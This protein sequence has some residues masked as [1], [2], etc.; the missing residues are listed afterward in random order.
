MNQ[1]ETVAPEHLL[2]AYCAIKA[3]ASWTRM[4]TGGLHFPVSAS[5]LGP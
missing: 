4:T 5:D 3:G 1:V 2:I